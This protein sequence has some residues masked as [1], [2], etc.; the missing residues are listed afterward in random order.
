MTDPLAS[1]P[2]VVAGW[3]VDPR[4]NELSRGGRTHRLEPKV[5]D[6]LVA[7]AEQPGE[8]VTREQLLERVWPG[9][10]VSESALSRCVSQLRKLFDDDPHEPRVIETLSKVGYRL[11]APVHP[12]FGGDSQGLD[13]AAPGVGDVALSVAPGLAASTAVAPVRSNRRTVLLAVAGV[14]LALIV[15]L[16][17]GLRGRPPASATITPLTTTRGTETDAAPS[18]DGSRVAY[19]GV[20]ETG[21]A[22][23]LFVQVLGASTALPLTRTGAAEWS[24]AWSP[25]ARQ[26]AFL[27]CVERAA[28]DE[29]GCAI[30]TVS[31]LGGDERVRVSRGVARIGGLDWSPDG[32]TLAYAAREAT[33][34]GAQRRA[35]L[36][37]LDVETGRTRRLT[38][39]PVGTPGDGQPRF[40]PD[41]RTIAF[42]RDVGGGLPDLYLVD[43]EG[44]T[45]RPLTRDRR[46]LAGHTWTADGRAVV[47]SSDRNG[48]FQ[49]WRVSSSGGAPEL[50]RG[51]PT[52]DPGG[53][54]TAAGDRLVFEEWEFETDVW[55]AVPGADPAPVVTSTWRD[56]YPHAVADGRLAFASDR[57]GSWEVWTARPDGTAPARLTHFDGSAAL[58]PR[59]SPD[60]TRIA[61]EVRDAGRAAVYVVGA[62]GGEPR[63][64]TPR[65]MDAVV[66]R[67][68]RDGR[69]LY[70]ASRGTDRWEVWRVALAGGAPVQVTRQGGYAME[71]LP[72]GR[73]VYSKYGERGLYV[74]ALA[75]GPE[76]LLY[77]GLAPADATNWWVDGA[78][79]VVPR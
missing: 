11:V 6:V 72:D 1:A 65:G 3:L 47:F 59:W 38:T 18:P 70:V 48:L 36:W 10:F 16:A 50:V 20:A 25:D 56:A 51:V 57:S 5:M 27:V 43:T 79:V 68:S 33:A 15:G 17:L 61:F 31:A 29:R 13:G 34:P 9:V 26:I 8:P 46:T 44:G 75:G 63:A 24:P 74:R 2:F 30:R 69:S 77:P 45:P 4:A 37:L 67:W 55:R 32:R 71:E 76:R 62:D 39:A 40:S 73:L 66:P 14:A 28:P 22:P 42:R 64:V 19:V 52:R 58:H 12:A 60:G 54:V 53:P 41:G 7:L 23:D 78:A 21:S 49:L 35:S